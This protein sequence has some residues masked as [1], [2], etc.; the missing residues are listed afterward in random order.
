MSE[1][2]SSKQVV[3]EAAATY[4]K[5]GM[6]LGLGTGST[7]HYF[8]KA[9]AA[10]IQKDALDVQGVCTSL[11]TEKHAKVLGIPLI[12]L[13]EAPHLDLCIDGA[14]EV[15]SEF[16]LIKG[17]GGALLREKVVASASE[18]VIII[19]GEGKYVETLGHNFLLPI[20]V[21]P[22]GYTQTMK[23]VAARSGC[24]PFLRT[25][26]GGEPFITDNG[27]YI[28]DCKFDKGIP[29][30]A[31][32][33]AILSQITGVVE[34]GIFLNLCD[35]VLESDSEGNLTTHTRDYARTLFT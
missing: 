8:L 16:R 22:F 3:G 24:T 5:S 23:Y 9:L 6:R 20:E 27:H 21:L 29:D 33:H 2:L 7:V 11:E 18:R 32:K 19:V 1:K 4:V 35:L 17:G 15:D 28:L 14:D 25:T 34:V 12:T 10:R 30:P 13:E 31:E 26:E